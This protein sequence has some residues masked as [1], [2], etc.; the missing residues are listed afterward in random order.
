V[1]SNDIALALVVLKVLGD[2]VKEGKAAADEQLRASAMPEDRT[3]A[4]LPDGAKVGTVNLNNGR[5]SARVTD[6]KAFT[7]WVQSMHPGEVE[8]V[9]TVR[10]AFEKLLLDGCKSKGGPVDKH[11]QEIPGV[12]VS[13]GDPY[14]MVKLVD[15]ASEAV[16][17]AWHARQLDEVMAGILR[18][19]IEAGGAA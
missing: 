12:T 2:Q 16:S 13:E 17:A 14:P 9:P 4:L 5:V 6:R 10:P 8:Q 7:A 19:A 1:I 11:G 18:P 15:G 3:A